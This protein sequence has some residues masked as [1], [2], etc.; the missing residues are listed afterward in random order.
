MLSIAKCQNS[1]L[2]LFR[3]IFNYFEAAFCVVFACPSVNFEDFIETVKK[4][5][6]QFLGNMRWLYVLRH[7]QRR[8]NK[9]HN[10]NLSKYLLE[11]LAKKDP[12]LIMFPFCTTFNETVKY[13]TL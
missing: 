5:I 2:E 8:W 10:V 9:L 1:N 3:Y 12:S 4:K 13:N 7:Y 11:F 6:N